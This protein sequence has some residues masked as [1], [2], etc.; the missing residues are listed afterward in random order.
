MKKRSM[1]TAMV[2]ILATMLAGCSGAGGTAGIAVPTSENEEE[3]FMLDGPPNHDDI[4][5]AEP[6]NGKFVSDHGTM[7]FD[8]DGESVTLELDSEIAADIGLPEGIYDAKYCLYEIVN[9]GGYL[10][11]DN[12]NTADVMYFNLDREG[13]EKEAWVSVGDG[14]YTVKENSFTLKPGDPETGV[15]PDQGLNN[16]QYAFQKDPEEEN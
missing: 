10:K 6:L 4:P 1:M 13:T 3:E 15:V 9:M 14:Y 12:Y 2:I 7:I 11:C 8:G 16:E 5:D